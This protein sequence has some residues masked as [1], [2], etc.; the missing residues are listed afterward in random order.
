MKKKKIVGLIVI[1]LVGLFL[2]WRVLP[3][4][5]GRIV[6]QPKMVAGTKPQSLKKIEIEK[7]VEAKVS[8][9]QIKRIK[10]IIYYE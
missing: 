3:P 4:R 10:T 1:F 6:Q 2:G 8:L 7:K 9:P 5:G